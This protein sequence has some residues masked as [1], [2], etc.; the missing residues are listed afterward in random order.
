VEESSTL[1]GSCRLFLSSNHNIHHHPKLDM[2]SEILEVERPT[3]LREKEGF[4]GDV[5]TAVG[6]QISPPAL[7]G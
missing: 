6:V 5:A 7:E 3:V 1:A 2:P 4:A